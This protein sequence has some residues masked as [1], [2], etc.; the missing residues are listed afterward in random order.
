M[1]IKNG[2]LDVNGNIFTFKFPNRSFQHFT[3]HYFSKAF[4]YVLTFDD[5][6]CLDLYLNKQW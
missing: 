4:G 1:N 2:L 5:F 6:T 3:Q